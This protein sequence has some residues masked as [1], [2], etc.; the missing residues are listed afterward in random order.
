MHSGFEENE[1]NAPQ[2]LAAGAVE[3]VAPRIGNIHCVSK[4]YSNRTP[5]VIRVYG[6]NI[7][8]ATRGPSGRQRPQDLY[9]R[10]VERRFT[11]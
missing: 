7:G 1:E 5:I 8:A 4:A 3:A 6:G 9:L 10:L 11:E 2:R